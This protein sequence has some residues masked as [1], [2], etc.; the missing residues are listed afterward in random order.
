M[1]AFS[2]Q[3]RLVEARAE[4]LTIVK[5]SPEHPRAHYELGSLHEQLG[6][7]REAVREFQIALQ[8]DPTSSLIK[9]KL[10]ELN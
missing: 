5:L 4:L 6:E 9:Q 10:K 8:L 1:H 7:R 2:C 3:G